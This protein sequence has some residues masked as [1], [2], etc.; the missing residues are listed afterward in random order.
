MT[1]TDPRR[2]ARRRRTRY[3]I[4]ATAAALAFGAGAF[5]MFGGPSDD[6]NTTVEAEQDRAVVPVETND[7]AELVDEWVQFHAGWAYVYEDGR[8]LW[9]T[10]GDERIVEQRLSP[11]G[12]DLV[13]AGE[14]VPASFVGGQATIPAGAWSDPSRDEYHPTKYAICP[15]GSSGTGGTDRGA[16]EI[17]A[18]LP[19]TVMAQVAGTAHPFTHGDWGG[20]AGPGGPASVQTC[21]ILTSERATAMWAH[22]RVEPG[23]DG[24][25]GVMR[26]SYLTFGAVTLT[27]GTSVLLWS[28]PILP[29]GVGGSWGG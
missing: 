8:V 9:R 11:L 28:L 29:H 23:G 12:L 1:V 14:I 17:E 7:A 19:Y 15:V 5:M 13:R 3:A 27:D 26:V 20:T 24:A 6:P 16:D 4:A 25:D 10:D 18:R 22:T 21:F 2:R